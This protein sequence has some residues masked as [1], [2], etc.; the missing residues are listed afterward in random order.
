MIENV[1]GDYLFKPLDLLS[2]CE[3]DGFATLNT[4]GK[5][6]P[7]KYIDVNKVKNK[8]MVSY[9]DH[10]CND[11][12]L[13]NPKHWNAFEKCYGNDNYD[14]CTMFEYNQTYYNTHYNDGY[15]QTKTVASNLV[16][17]AGLTFDG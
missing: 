17:I 2:N 5:W 3:S 9:I 10:T 7:W 15:L 13:S 11:A 6:C 12:S 14:Y 8:I 4:D 1:I 16:Q